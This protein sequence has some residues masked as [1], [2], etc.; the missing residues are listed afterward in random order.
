MATGLQGDR[1]DRRARGADEAAWRRSPLET[2]AWVDFAGNDVIFPAAFL[3]PPFYDPKTTL[4][5]RYGAIG[6]HL[7]HELTHLFDNEGARYDASGKIASWWTP[8]TW[9]RFEGRTS[10]LEQQFAAYEPLPGVHVDAKRT[11][12]ENIAD[13]GGLKLAFRAYR[14]ARRGATEVTVADGYTEDQQFFLSYAQDHCVKFGARDFEVFLAVNVHA[15]H[16]LRVNGAG[17]NLPELDRAFGCK[18]PEPAPPC[19]EVW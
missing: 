6:F 3:E 5:V 14:E 7:G 19:C 13:L 2:N 12:G 15:P 11:L 16:W 17:R 8:D 1:L 18:R 4:P 9:K 10:C